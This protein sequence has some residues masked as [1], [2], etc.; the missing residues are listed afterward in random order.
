VFQRRVVDNFSIRLWINL[1]K[2]RE[3]YSQHNLTFSLQ[4]RYDR[5]ACGKSQ[6]IIQ[7][8]IKKNIYRRRTAGFFRKLTFSTLFFQRKNACRGIDRH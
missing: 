3:L 1:W 4:V 2:I 5:N 8:K 6:K 7:K